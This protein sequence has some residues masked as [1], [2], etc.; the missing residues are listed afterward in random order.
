[1]ILLWPMGTDLCFFQRTLHP[2]CTAS[3][4]CCAIKLIPPLDGVFLWEC[5][6]VFDLFPVDSF[7]N[8]LKISLKKTKLAAKL[9]R[10]WRFWY[11]YTRPEYRRLGRLPSRTDL[12][13]SCHFLS[14]RRL[15]RKKLHSTRLVFSRIFLR[16]LKYSAIVGTS[17]QQFN[18]C[19]F[20]CLLSFF[21]IDCTRKVSF[22]SIKTRKLWHKD[23]V[24]VYS[25]QFYL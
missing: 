16:K 9:V 5:F 17:T 14:I 2:A 8:H 11:Y 1:M 4:R 3:P 10:T 20:N 21:C 15:T 22:K 18:F 13:S 24:I 19:F 6:M 25:Y 23:I 12:R 7:G